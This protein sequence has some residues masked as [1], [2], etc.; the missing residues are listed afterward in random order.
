MNI[1]DITVNTLKLCKNG[2]CKLAKNPR[3][4]IFGGMALSTAGTVVACAQTYKHTDRILDETKER[5]ENAENGKDKAKAVGYCAAEF[6]KS[7]AVPAAMVVGGNI[8]IGHG[9]MMHEK[10]ENHL[11]EAA[12]TWAAGYAALRKRMEEKLG[13]EAADDIRFGVE[14]VKV[15]EEVEKN[16][17]KK[18]E[19]KIE[20]RINPDTVLDASPLARFFDKT[21]S[22]CAS[23][24][25]DPVADKEYNVSFL[26]MMQKECQ[27]LLDNHMADIITWPS[28]LDKIGLEIKTADMTA[29]WL[30][31]DTVDFG[32]MEASKWASDNTKKYLYDC[33]LLNPNCR[34]DVRPYLRESDTKELLDKM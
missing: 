26:N 16:G 29:A 20:K 23:N 15:T 24:I 11:A 9:N 25:G 6:A 12:A 2:L 18:K 32:I 30:P 17:K 22:S 28:V 33:V 10:Y 4:F 8:A 34:L 19:E 14:E 13:K 27:S 1:L 31:G 21:V 7:F 3:V 5:L